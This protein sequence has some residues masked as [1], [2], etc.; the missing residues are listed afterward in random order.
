MLSMDFGLLLLRLA[1][2]LTMA[3][4]GAQKLF[5]VFG[6]HGLA[7]TAGFLESLGFRPGRPHAW[8]VG[9]AELA[10]GLL[11]ALGWLTPLGAAAVIAVMVGAIAAVHAA[12]GFFITD[13]GIEY[14]LLLAVVAAALAFIGPGDVSLDAALGWT[15]AGAAWGLGAVGTGSLV[16]G[17][18]L[19]ARRRR[20]WSGWRAAAPQA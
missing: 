3:A 16:A 19:A 4:H 13:G 17:V 2:G 11:L 7:G 15:L 14:A 20:A 9:L 12:K 10:G 8:A 1:I 5:G 18:V 6:G